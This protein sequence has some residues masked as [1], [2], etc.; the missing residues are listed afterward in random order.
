MM[1]AVSSTLTSRAVDDYDILIREV[2]RAARSNI[3]RIRSQADATGLVGAMR[4]VLGR[5][6][7][8]LTDGIVRA[9]GDVLEHGV[10]A[11]ARLYRPLGVRFNATE[12]ELTIAAAEDDFFPI[13][14]QALDSLRDQLAAQLEQALVLLPPNASRAQ[15]VRAFAETME[16]NRWRMERIARTQGNLAF[17]RA[18]QLLAERARARGE[19]TYLRWTEMIDDATGRPLDDRVGIDSIIMHGQVALPGGAFT[20]PTVAKAPAYLA[21][22]SWTAPPNR[23]NDRAVLTPWT[24]A[25]G[26]KGWLWRRG[27]KVRPR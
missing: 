24:P 15:Y 5:T 1:R 25:T 19:R 23:P 17:N 20:M 10:A 8:R 7:P 27:R 16:A 22:R 4:Q 14:S 18:A 21:G 2:S 12:L 3:P 11:Q 26:V 9:S 13:T 6:M